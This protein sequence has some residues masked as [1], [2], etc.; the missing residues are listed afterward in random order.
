MVKAGPKITLGADPEFELVVGGRVAS[1]SSILREDIHLPWGDIGVDG[2][3]WPLELRPNPSETARGLVANVGRLLVAV[4]KVLGGVPSTMCE[5]YAIGGHVHIGFETAPD[6][7]YQDIVKTIDDVLGDILYSLNTRTRVSAGYGRRGDWRDQRWGVE[8]RTPPA[9]V[10][11]HP[12]VALTFVG[13]IKWAV[14]ELLMGEDPRKSPALERVRAAAK[15][16]AAF[17]KRYNG[18]LHWGAWQSLVGEVDLTRHLGVKIHFDSGDRDHKFF[19]DLEAM[20]TRLGLGSVR[21]V[22]LRQSRGDYASNVPGYGTLVDGFAEF[23]PGGT[24]CLSWRFRNDPEFRRQEMPKLEAAIA[25][26]MRKDEADDNRLVKEVIPLKVA[27]A[28]EEP[29]LE[30][31]EVQNS[32]NYENYYVC[33]GCGEDVHVEDVLISRSG[34]AYCPD[35]YHDRYTRCERCDREV[36]RDDAYYSEDNCG[37]YCERCYSELYVRCERCGS[38]VCY[39]DSYTSDD[40]YIY[41]EECYDELF[42]TCAHCER[43]VQRDDAYYYDDEAYCEECYD[44]LFAHCEGCD[45]EYPVEDVSLARVRAKTGEVYEVGLC[46]EC[47]GGYYRYDPEEDVW[48]EV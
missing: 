37:P 33:D 23:T 46:S 35:C 34:Y 41:C 19:G 27:G 12:G 36:H 21:I 3:G 6:L 26:L 2:A 29:D 11:S 40:G 45:A 5:V 20:C 48:V 42:T 22:S 14:Q 44:E 28:A 32:R 18:R 8:Y 7:A 24:L 10:W 38:E 1:A 47:R 17:V 30:P 15:N 9:A 16:A 31:M 25:D 39:E 43:E 13:A 4:P